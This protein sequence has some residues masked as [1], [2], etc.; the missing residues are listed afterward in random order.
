MVNRETQ[1]YHK[2][3]LKMHITK[4]RPKTALPQS[5]LLVL[6]AMVS[7]HLP[8]W[9][10]PRNAHLQVLNSLRLSHRVFP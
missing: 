10:Q 2:Q 8:D 7:V 9:Q 4:A 1:C 6:R 5:R 3:T